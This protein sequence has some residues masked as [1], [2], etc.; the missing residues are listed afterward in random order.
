M[1]IIEDTHSKTIVVNVH[2]GFFFHS[3]YSTVQCTVGALAS[4]VPY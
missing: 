4:K 3:F 2:G 1:S